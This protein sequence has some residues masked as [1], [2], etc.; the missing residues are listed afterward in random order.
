MAIKHS[1][2]RWTLAPAFGALLVVALPA[3]AQE[4]EKSSETPAPPAA[5]AAPAAPAA[6]STPPGAASSRETAAQLPPNA[7]VPGRPDIPNAGIAAKM[8]NAPQPPLP[9]AADKLPIAKLK[10]PK[11]FKIEVYASGISNARSLRLTDK[12]TLFVGNRVFDKVYAV[13]DQNGKREVKFI[14]SGLDRPNGL[15]F[16]N[17]TL[18]VA[19]GTKISK[20]EKIEDN[21]NAPPKPV[22]IYSDLP[23]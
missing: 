13:V 3:L 9:A 5:A 8:R 10:V 6:P 19:E 12:G 21:L 20:L 15:A 4:S 2:C 22:V 14:A 17:G 1:Q 11:G 23:N 16:L 7:S 18:Y